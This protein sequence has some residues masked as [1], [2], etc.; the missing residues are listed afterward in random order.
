MLPDSMR[1]KVEAMMTPEAMGAM[2]VVLGA[3]A[4]GHYFGISEVIDVLAVV[5]LVAAGV[6]VA[7]VGQKL[8]DGASL[9][10][11]AQTNEERSN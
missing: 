11:T 4:V 6:E 2:T 3:W 9:A 5:G 7:D 8:Y 10:M 1:S